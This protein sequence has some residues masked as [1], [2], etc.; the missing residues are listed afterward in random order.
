MPNPLSYYNENHL[1]YFKLLGHIIGKSIF[2][3]KYID[4]CFT[5]PFYKNIVDI[6]IDYIDM[7]LIDLEY[8]KSLV[9]L[10]E[11]DIQQLDLDL[12]FSLDVNKFGIKTLN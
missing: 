9:R 11:N 5:R 8:Y 6:L 3:N 2:D 1:E 10:F 7:E 4:R 12:T